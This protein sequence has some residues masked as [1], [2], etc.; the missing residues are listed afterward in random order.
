MYIVS[1]IEQL[2]L[3]QGDVFFPCWTNKFGDKL[4]NWSLNCTTVIL[5]HAIFTVTVILYINY[6]Y[7]DAYCHL[8]FKGILSPGSSICG[9]NLKVGFQVSGFPPDNYR[10]IIFTVYQKDS[11]FELKKHAHI[12]R[13]ATE[14]S[15]F[16]IY[17]FPA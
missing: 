14:L 17:C 13:V 5:Y 9:L 6:Y 1:G 3:E 10:C 8:N 16:E 7:Y 11:V 12:T 4:L 15:Y 2:L